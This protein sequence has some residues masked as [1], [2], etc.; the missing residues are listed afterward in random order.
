MFRM[1]LVYTFIGGILIHKKV[2]LLIKK[3]AIIVNI[4]NFLCI[5]L[6]HL[7]FSEK[8]AVVTN[9]I[10]DLTVDFVGLGSFARQ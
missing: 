9:V 10:V 7:C 2:K 4:F 1:Q 6:Y 5:S 8:H 3:R